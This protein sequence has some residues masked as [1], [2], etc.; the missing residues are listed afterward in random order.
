MNCLLTIFLPIQIS[1]ITLN[2]AT[3]HFENKNLV[4]TRIQHGGSTPTARA[5]A[6]NSSCSLR[7]KKNPVATR[8][9]LHYLLLLLRLFE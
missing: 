8:E 9:I 2:I 4:K 7:A 6:D 5:R 3:I 1:N